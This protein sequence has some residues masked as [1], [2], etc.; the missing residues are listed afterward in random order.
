MTKTQVNPNDIKPSETENSV[1]QTISGKAVWSNSPIPP[2]VQTTG[3]SVTNVMSQNAVTSKI[4]AIQASILDVTYTDSVAPANAHRIGYFQD[5]GSVERAVNETVTR[6]VDNGNK[7]YTYT[8]EA[9]TSTVINAAGPTV[10]QFPGSSTTSVM[11][12]KAF[13][14]SLD[15]MFNQI[16][17]ITYTSTSGTHK[18]GSLHEG[19]GETVDIKESVSPL[20]DNGDGT[21]TYTD[22][23]GISTTFS[24]GGSSSIPTLEQVLNSGDKG[25]DLQK[26][27]MG[28][29]ATGYTSTFDYSGLAVTSDG[30]NFTNVG[31]TLVQVDNGSGD[32]ASLTALGLSG[33]D[34]AKEATNLWLGNVS[35]ESGRV[36]GAIQHSLNI[37]DEFE[38]SARRSGAT[39]NLKFN[40]S[41]L[42]DAAIPPGSI[43]GSVDEQF[44]SDTEIFIYARSEPGD[45]SNSRVIRFSEGI[46]YL[47]NG[48]QAGESFGICFDTIYMTNY[49]A[50]A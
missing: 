43:I 17:T 6:M 36:E 22:E 7:T 41:V 19:N 45:T 37:V 28:D 50:T 38:N 15:L 2:V 3:T 29:E 9:G 47:V 31:P 40:V 10:V 26:I 1:I 13:T 33:T 32:N 48:Q 16:E 24:T 20:V 4:N 14:D 11:S 21:Y 42:G 25:T 18:I 30:N 46:L 44:A 5:G 34:T 35:Q 8:N 12:Q 49:W 39:V 27:M 23:S